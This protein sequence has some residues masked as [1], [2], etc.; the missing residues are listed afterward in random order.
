MTHPP[1]YKAVLA[2]SPPGLLGIPAQDSLYTAAAEALAR[3]QR[4]LPPGSA[5]RYEQGSHSIAR[6]RNRLVEAV[7]ATPA[8]AWCLFIDSDAVPAPVTAARLLSHPV[9]IVASV[10]AMRCP[11]HVGVH[12][13]PIGRGPGELLEVEYTGFHAVL[14]RRAVFE[15]VPGPWFEHPEP[16]QGED[17]YFCDRVRAHG[18]RVYLDPKF[19]VGHL[20]VTSIDSADTNVYWETAA[21][22]AALDSYHLKAEQAPGRAP[23]GN[24][25]SPLHPNNKSV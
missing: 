7:L 3:L 20:T 13:E 14:V 9:D 22:R 18:E 10:A 6:K 8:L 11:P 17:D 23:D 21:G 5:V 16:G 24:E 19:E 2:A 4:F 1:D 25:R 15:R 12:G